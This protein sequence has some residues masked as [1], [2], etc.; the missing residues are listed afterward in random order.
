MNTYGI[1]FVKTIPLLLPSYKAMIEAMGGPVY[2]HQL[3]YT[4]SET[5]DAIAHGKEVRPKFTILRI[6]ER[7]GH[8]YDLAD[9]I[10]KGLPE[11]K[12]Y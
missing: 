9:E 8:L 1:D 5:Y 7:F 11:G 3:G 2:P 10:A 6:A 4:V 12:I